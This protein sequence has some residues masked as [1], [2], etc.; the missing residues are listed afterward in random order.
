VNKRELVDA[1]S[2]KLGPDASR[3][4]VEETIT[5]FT[6]TV[7]ETLRKGDSVQLV[8]FGTFEARKRPARTARNP[9]TGAPIKVK[10]TVAPAFKAG[11]G[12]KNVVA[13]KVAVKKSTA[14]KATAKKATARKATKKAAA[15]KR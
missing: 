3:K 4:A 5:A 2:A 10:A 12:L 11:Q 1:I 13:K 14:K 6:D 7:A 15:R 9:Q 8:G